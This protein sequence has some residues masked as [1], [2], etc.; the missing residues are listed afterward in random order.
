MISKKSNSSPTIAA[1]ATPH[2]MGSISIIR[3]SGS[4]ALPIIEQLT[5]INDT[6]KA[7]TPRYAHLYNLYDGDGQL[8]DKAIIIYF[9]APHSFTGEDIVEIQSHGG[10]IIS[11]IVLENLLRLG[12]SLAKPGEFSK[13]AF[14]NEKIDLSQAESIAQMIASKSETM[15][16][17]I[18]RNLRGDI[19]HFVNATREQLIH[20]LAYSEVSIDYAEEALPANLLEQMREQLDGIRQHIDTI[21]NY[22]QRRLVLFDGLKVVFIGKPNVG[23]SSLL[24][25]LLNESKAIVSDQAGTTRDSI[26]GT[27]LIN[28]Q[29]IQLIDTAGI[30]TSENQIEQIGVQKSLEHLQNSDMI[31]ALFDSSSPLDDEDMAI[32]NILQPLMPSKK[33]IFTLNKSDLTQKINFEQTAI[34]PHITPKNRIS[35][36]CKADNIDAL[37][38]VLEQN[39]SIEGNYDDITLTSQRQ[40]NSF[41]SVYEHISQ[42]IHHLND[43]ELDLFSYHIQQAIEQ[44]SSVTKPFA[45]SELL[46][47]I[48]G[49]FCL[50]K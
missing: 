33:V 13:R 1:I 2:G 28:G 39:V 43:E 36:S 20:I 45:Y 40:I 8:I 14:F 26:E 34:N 18:A 10:I 29:I 5:T 11:K 23:K 49:N 48:F 50:G 32:L 46:D 30:R 35:I 9:K 38:K 15:V 7:F 12:A 47:E 31:I 42:S 44:I 37:I 19:G 27:I 17:D 3:M 16:K 22:S 41:E 25:A 24:N 4:K 6:V 21:K